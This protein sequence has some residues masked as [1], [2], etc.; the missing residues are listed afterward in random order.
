M[1]SEATM[2]ILNEFKMPVQPS[3]D[4]EGNDL[5]EESIIEQAVS[6]IYKMEQNGEA[7]TW[8][9]VAENMGFRLETLN[10]ADM[11]LLHDAIEHA[12]ALPGIEEDDLNESMSFEKKDG[13]YYVYSN[14]VRHLVSKETYEKA[15][16]DERQVKI[17][18]MNQRDKED[19]EKRNKKDWFNESHLR[20]VVAESVKKA[21]N[22]DLDFSNAQTQEDTENIRLRE[23]LAY[24]M[25]THQQLIDLFY[26]SDLNGCRK[27]CSSVNY[28]IKGVLPRNCAYIWT[29]LLAKFSKFS[30]LCTGSE[31]SN[32]TGEL[33][34]DEEA[35]R[36]AQE[37]LSDIRDI[38][39]KIQEMLYPSSG[40]LNNV[41]AEG[42]KKALNETC[43]YGDKKPFQTILSA[44]NEIMDKFE[45]TQA[46]DYDDMGDCDG[47][48]IT[49]NIYKWAERVADDA[50]YWLR[51]H[52]SNT[53]INGGEDW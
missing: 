20:K 4:Y 17:H 37:T 46:D 29:E 34:S 47:P 49:P 44:A 1:V 35:R 15:Q 6:T 27:L 22:E 36:F 39:L 5:S 31:R 12:M 33:L 13:K 50:E 19:R 24:A 16:E 21:L 41:V 28:E 8:E 2:K 42:V 23:A 25:R 48:D 32:V 18:K 53:S 38:L 11:E 10:E 7:I 45:H 51:Y 14:G 9:A 52:S 40:R 30:R 26:R 3:T 43:W